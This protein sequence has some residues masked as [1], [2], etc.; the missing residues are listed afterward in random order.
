MPRVERARLIDL[1]KFRGVVLSLRM[2][3]ATMISYIILSSVM[4]SI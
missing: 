4:S 2:S 3:G 1:V